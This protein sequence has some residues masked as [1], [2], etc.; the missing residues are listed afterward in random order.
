MTGALLDRELKVTWLTKA[1]ALAA[2]QVPTIEARQ[3]L[4]ERLIAE[5]LGQEAAAK[6]VTAL[7]RVWL[8]PVERGDFWTCWPLQAERD[9]RDLRPFHFGALLATEPF[10]R[11]LLEAVGREARASETVNTVAVRKRLRDQHGPRRA[12]DVAAQRG[13]KTLRELGVLIGEPSNSTSV[14][15]KLQITDAELAAWLVRC[16]L[17]A[18]GAESIP[19]ADLGH[20]PEFF[21]LVL[22]RALPRKAAGITQY[23]EGLG[24]T[25]LVRTMMPMP[26]QLNE[27][28]IALR[29]DGGCPRGGL[30]VHRR[31]RG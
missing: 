7:S 5:G 24:R 1:L 8:L 13:I 4:R 6:T 11:S 21:G 30:M 22:P 2:D 20:A 23:A 9:L 31:R 27:P 10:F 16:L 29:A 14:V 25:V 19:L 15:G 17:E 26:G 3:L 12:I 18:R 28:S